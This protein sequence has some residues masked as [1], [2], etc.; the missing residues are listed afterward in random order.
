MATYEITR[1]DQCGGEKDVY[2]IIVGY[3]KP[4]VKTWEA[5]ICEGCYTGMFGEI[6]R[7]SKPSK[8]SNIRPQHRMVM[9]EI[10]DENL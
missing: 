8:A 5:D 4:R 9:T 1:C 2:K 7:K 3:R 6:A 10:S